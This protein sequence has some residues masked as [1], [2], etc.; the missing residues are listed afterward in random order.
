MYVSDAA[1]P[2]P[3]LAKAHVFLQFWFRDSLLL[4]DLTQAA[5]SGRFGGLQALRNHLFPHA[6]RATP[7]PRG[8]RGDF[9]GL[10]ALQ[11]SRFPPPA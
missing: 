1:N 8:E 6:A 2:L 9:G 5:E 4:T 11:T 3:I 10:A 7:A